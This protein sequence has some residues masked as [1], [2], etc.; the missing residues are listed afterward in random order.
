MEL[1]EQQ[2]RDR[3]I[4]SQSRRL[5]K[6]L[7]KFCSTDVWLR[8]QEVLDNDLRRMPRMDH[9]NVYRIV[10]RHAATAPSCGY[11]QGNL[12]ILYLIGLVFRDERSIFW[13]YARL[14]LAQSRYGPNTA[15][16]RLVI[17]DWVL[18]E[19]E[20]DRE[21]W[22]LMIRL[23]WLFIIFGQTFPDPMNLCAIVDYAL[24]GEDHMHSICAA[25][26]RHLLPACTPACPMERMAELF[27]MQIKD[28]R[29]T[30]LIIGLAS[31][32]LRT[33]P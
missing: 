9:D 5:P 17:P 29:S 26:I 21:L 24:R 27:G 23:R 15:Y 19:E 10:M 7:P 11:I 16:G 32:I 14:T 12:Y 22:D 2:W 4:G 20:V 18:P 6:M 8:Q 31:Q 25:L 3:L 30:A 33:K 28:Q 1:R 13:A